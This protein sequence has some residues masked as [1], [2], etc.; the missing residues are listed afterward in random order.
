MPTHFYN[1]TLKNYIPDANFNYKKVFENYDFSL[2]NLKSLFQRFVKVDTLA[3]WLITDVLKFIFNLK[4]VLDLQRDRFITFIDTRYNRLFLIFYNKS[5]DKFEFIWYNKVS[6]W[7]PKRWKDYYPT[8]YLIIDRQKL[9]FYKKDRRAKGIDRM[10]Y[11]PKGSRIFYL[12]KYYINPKTKEVSLKPKI[13]FKEFH[14]AFHTTTPWGLTQL[15]KPMSKWCI[16]TSRFINQLYDFY[17][18]L[19]KGI[20]I[21]GDLNGNKIYE[22]SKNDINLINVNNFKET[23][24]LEIWQ[25]EESD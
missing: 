13:W 5:K 22:V 24:S 23:I 8:P 2:D 12:W 15:W 17:D 18:E 6:T 4:E 19:N 1:I 3:D 14:L 25:N 10:W 16:R 11:W 9:W 21:I 7:N 20:F